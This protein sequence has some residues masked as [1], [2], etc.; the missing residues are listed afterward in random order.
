[1]GNRA[2][3]V[4]VAILAIAVMVGSGCVS[5]KQY[6]TNVDDSD[7]RMGAVEDAV[8]SNERRI[9]DLGKET[10]QKIA[11]V[12]G[13]ANQAMDSSKQAMSAAEAAANGRLIWDVT[14]TDDD[15]KFDFGKAEL[16]SGS[17]SELDQ[18][19]SKVKGFGRAIY[20]EVEGHTDN[21]GTPGLNEKL[22]W[23]RAMVV[24]G[25]LNEKGIPL[26]AISTVSFGESR[27]I[28]DNSTKD[29]RAQNRRVVIRV[30]E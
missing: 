29:G 26:H 9:S 24:R 17:T 4:V 6:Q 5:K 15:L 8:E 19:I 11:S 14:I 1:M 13:K 12:D 27:P 25:Y 30:L 3:A 20:I 23:E 18:L 2:A 22:G 16:D 7:R 21:V 28:A 10:D